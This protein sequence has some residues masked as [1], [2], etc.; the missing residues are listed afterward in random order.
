M[1]KEDQILNEIKEV[2]NL[3]AV[4]IGTSEQPANTR[5]SEEAISKAA[6]EFKDL[7]IQRGEWISEYEVSR[8]F[9][10][11]PYYTGKFIIENFAFNNYFTKGKSRFY[12]RK[13]ILALGK[14]LKNRNVNL[15]KYIKLV[16]DKE[17]FQKN[18][19]SAKQKKGNR[20]I[21]SDELKDVQPSPYPLPSISI[22]QEHINSLMVEF[23]EGNIGKFVDLY[24][25]STYAMYKM[26]YQF[27]RYIDIKIKNTCKKW[28]ENFNYANNAL[29]LVQK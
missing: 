16:E 29:Q 21:I 4:L 1:E 2:H 15:G 3:I 10:D 6:R 9:R 8:F 28:C 11:S 5:F 27:D 24:E 13:D 23:Q 20:F 18:I 26:E 19:E 22:I 25:N 17:K 12:N 7:S 14:E